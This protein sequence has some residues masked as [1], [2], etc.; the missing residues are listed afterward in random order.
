MNAS[1]WRNFH[2]FIDTLDVAMQQQR[3]SI[4]TAERRLTVAR[5]DWQQKKQKLDSYETLL[6][7]RQAT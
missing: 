7:A 1:H 2:Q 5:A 3:L 4:E 6:G